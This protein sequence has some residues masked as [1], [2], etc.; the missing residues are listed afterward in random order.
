MH[1]ISQSLLIL[2]LYRSSILS[3]RGFTDFE[4][5]GPHNA[6]ALCD[7][8]HQDRSSDYCSSQQ[9]KRSRSAASENTMP[10]KHGNTRI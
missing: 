6:M 5:T 8:C 3:A 10:Q 9:G 1:Y 4:L 7:H 2:T